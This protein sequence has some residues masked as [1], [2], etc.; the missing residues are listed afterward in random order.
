MSAIS[1]ATNKRQPVT[2]AHPSNQLNEGFQFCRVYH[3]PVRAELAT[4]PTTRNNIPNVQNQL[5]GGKNN[6]ITKQKAKTI[7]IQ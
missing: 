6:S 2:A 7:P 4:T 5:A 1:G 3:C